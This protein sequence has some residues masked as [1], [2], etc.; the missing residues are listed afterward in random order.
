MW[1]H[2]VSGG[3]GVRLR[4][5]EAGDPHGTPLL[6]LHGWSQCGLCWAPQFGSD[7]TRDFRLVAVDLR[8]HGWSDKPAAGYDDPALWAADLHAVITELDLRGPVVTAWSYGGL[9]L[10]DYLRTHG[11]GA[12]GGV[13][14]VAAITELGTSRAA[15]DVGAEFV[16]AARD[17]Y[18]SDV[19]EC[20]AGIERYLRVVVGPDLPDADLALLIGYNAL[21]PPPVRR[22]LFRRRVSNDDVLTAL[23]VPVLISHGVDDAVVLPAAARHAAELIGHARSSVYPATGHAP[24]VSAP[25][26]FNRELREFATLCQRPA[27]GRS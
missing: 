18:S 20:L 12:L 11:D 9:V 8:G 15:T 4:V 26:R 17:S 1:Q 22:Q 25:A 24:F 3:G 14:L 2:L 21:V 5:R 10:C 27:P 7:L 6:F 16:T 13:H 23:A 19:A